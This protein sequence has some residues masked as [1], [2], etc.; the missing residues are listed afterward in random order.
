MKIPEMFLFQSERVSPILLIYGN[1][2]TA[3][4]WHAHR[5]QTTPYFWAS[6]RSA[7]LPEQVRTNDAQSRHGK[8][9]M[10]YDVGSTRNPVDEKNYDFRNGNETAD[11]KYMIIFIFPTCFFWQGR[12]KENTFLFI[13]LIPAKNEISNDTETI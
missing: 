6:R 9:E 8:D 11:E 4:K 13:Y 5:R 2:A 12:T 10:E 7:I 1:V 3:I